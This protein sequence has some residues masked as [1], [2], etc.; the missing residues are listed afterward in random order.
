MLHLFTPRALARA[1][2]RVAVSA[3]TAA[4]VLAVGALVP[5]HSQPAPVAPDIAAAAAAPTAA[6]PHLAIQ[7]PVPLQSASL[8]SA[9][10]PADLICLAKA[11]YYE[12]RGESAQG[13]T[14]VAEV[15]LNRTRHGH[16]PSNVCGVVFQG[17]RSGQCQFSF[18]CNGAMDRPM[19]PA[20]W[21]RARRV[22][23]QT[24]TGQCANPVGQAV[25]FHA[26]SEA[27]RRGG[28]RIG[29]HIFFGARS[30][31]RA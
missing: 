30:S 24:L 16:Y 14:A 7:S 13:Q 3:T 2:F 19:E 4:L 9:A 22:A 26:V 21:S 31:E 11:V 10:R 27:S 29:G 28:L 25:S 18:V 6:P 1:P 12:A 15:V 17:Q 23:A 5:L 8:S 20:A